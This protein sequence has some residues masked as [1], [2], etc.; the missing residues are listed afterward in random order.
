[1]WAVERGLA[2]DYEVSAAKAFAAQS[3]TTVTA[4]AVQLHGGIGY[5]QEY[6]LQ[7]YF[8]RARSEEV[9]MGTTEDH[10]E[11]VAVALGL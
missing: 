7:F 4:N 8:R 6:D 3:Y 2:A 10:L 11:R 5:M 9:L 1:V